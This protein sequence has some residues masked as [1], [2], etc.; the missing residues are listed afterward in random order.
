MTLE[1]LKLMR[2]LGG[3]TPEK[4]STFLSFVLFASWP[5]NLGYMGEGYYDWNSLD[6]VSSPCLI[7]GLQEDGNLHSQQWTQRNVSLDRKK[8]SRLVSC[9]YCNKL[10]QWGGLKLQNLFY[11]NSGVQKSKIKKPKG[12]I[13]QNFGKEVS[14][15]FW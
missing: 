2:G 6:E 12:Q 13:L 11:H 14:S 7:F 4:H 9:G 10:L 3:R 1:I 5:I 15:R 8:K